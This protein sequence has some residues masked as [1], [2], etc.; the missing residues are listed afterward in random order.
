MIDTF[1]LQTAENVSRKNCVSE[2]HSAPVEE[3]EAT[4]L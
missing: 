2:K 1:I 4:Y 3:S